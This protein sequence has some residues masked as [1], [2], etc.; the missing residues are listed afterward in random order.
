MS[1]FRKPKKPML[2]K[3]FADDE[4]KMDID[5]EKSSKD[6][7]RDRDRDKDKHRSDRD[8]S[9]QKVSSS[10]SST[11]S[12]A[13]LE[14]KPKALL[15]FADDVDGKLEKSTKLGHSSSWF[16]VVN[17]QMMAKYSK[18]KNLHTARKFQGCWTRSD[19]KK[20]KKR[21]IWRKIRTVIVMRRTGLKMI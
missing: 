5:V 11:S 2:R 8:K 7:H 18:L 6:R 16:F 1:M 13:G 21:E 12:S 14:K 9:K 4:E 3:V 15:S 19:E 10:S 17:L 20:P